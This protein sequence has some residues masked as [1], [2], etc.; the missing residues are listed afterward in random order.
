MDFAGAIETWRRVLTQPGE[1]VFEQEKMSPN[2]TL[3]TAL[4]WMVIAG[5]VAA[6]FGWLAGLMGAASMSA[7]IS[8]MGLPPEMQAQ[9]GPMIAAMTGSAGLAAIITVP[10]F[11]LIGTFILH[12]I[13]KMLG[14]QGEYSTLAYL[15][16]TFQAPLTIISSILA[17]IPFLGGCVAFLIFIYTYVEGYFAVKANYGLTSGRA[18]AVILIPLAL[19]FILVFCLAIVAGGILAGLS[20]SN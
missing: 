18:I 19:L 15:F 3:Q 10:L 4:I 6:I 16:A 12:L 2:A 9:M 17:I 20:G 1:P 13:A 5:V 14:G 8:Q 7:M 11:F